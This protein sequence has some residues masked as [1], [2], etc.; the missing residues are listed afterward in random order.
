MIN[1]RYE[2]SDPVWAQ[3]KSQVARMAA[4]EGGLPL[5]KEG[6]RE[7]CVALCNCD[8]LDEVRQVVDDFVWN[9]SR[10]PTPAD[11]R[12]KIHD[13]HDARDGGEGGRSLKRWQEEAK[14]GKDPLEGLSGI[15]RRGRDP[16]A[17]HHIELILARNKT[18]R[19][20]DEWNGLTAQLH[21]IERSWGKRRCEPGCTCELA[22]GAA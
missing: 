17:D 4:M 21:A 6:T 9:E 10:R 8:S 2:D 3:I 12:R 7:M 16:E 14:R 19:G 5:T 18:K 20:S 13:Q 1:C 22:G 15:F 11:I